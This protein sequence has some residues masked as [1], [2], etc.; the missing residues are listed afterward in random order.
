MGPQLS[1]VI[2]AECHNTQWLHM[3]R[4]YLPPIRE[5]PAEVETLNRDEIEVKLYVGAGDVFRA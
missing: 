2:D 5:V 4:N 1:I 3:E